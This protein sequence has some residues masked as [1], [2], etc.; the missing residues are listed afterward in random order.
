MKTDI[1]NSDE[2]LHGI[3]ETAELTGFS[4]PQLRRMHDTGRFRAKVI[5]RGKQLERL[6]SDDDIKSLIDIRIAK[7]RYNTNTREATRMALW[8]AVGAA[9]NAFRLVKGWGAPKGS[10]SRRGIQCPHC[11]QYHVP[12]AAEVDEHGRCILFYAEYE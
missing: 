12:A 4:I 5:R 3:T 7:H 9:M 10:K 6:Y 11:G 1:L 2:G 8:D